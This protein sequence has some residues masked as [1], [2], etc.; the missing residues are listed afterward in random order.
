MLMI[1]DNN[2]VIV[3]YNEVTDIYIYIYILECRLVCDL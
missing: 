1:I 3:E 2:L